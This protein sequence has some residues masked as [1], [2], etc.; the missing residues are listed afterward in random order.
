TSRLRG[1]FRP[2]GTGLSAARISKST[3]NTGTLSPLAATCCARGCAAGRRKPATSALLP[4][5]ER[6]SLSYLRAVVRGKLKP[7]GLSSL[8]NNFI[9]TE[10]LDAARESART[11]KRVKLAGR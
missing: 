2:P 1:S 9:V 4:P 11:G 6:D 3:A 5:D 7:S 8:K 10:I